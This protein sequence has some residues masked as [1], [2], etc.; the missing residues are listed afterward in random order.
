MYIVLRVVNVF[1]GRCE[2]LIVLRFVHFFC[3]AV[4]GVS[5]SSICTLFF[6][7]KCEVFIVLRF[8]QIF[9]RAV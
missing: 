2:V 9:C 4:G 5:C 1:V 7:G 6:V 3:R 8:V